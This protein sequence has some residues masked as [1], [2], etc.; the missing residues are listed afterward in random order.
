[1]KLTS[2]RCMI[3]DTW[4]GAWRT[5]CDNCGARKGGRTHYDVIERG[6]IELVRGVPLPLDRVIRKFE[7]K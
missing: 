1:M 5:H 6:I 2:I 3:C 7:E 4:R